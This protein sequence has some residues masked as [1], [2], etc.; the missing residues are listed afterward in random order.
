MVI[1]FSY[2]CSKPYLKSSKIINSDYS[3]GRGRNNRIHKGNIKSLKRANEY[4]QKT[5]RKQEKRLSNIIKMQDEKS[6]RIAK[7]KIHI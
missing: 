3:P 5:K 7:K 1:Y 4:D 6:L 2:N